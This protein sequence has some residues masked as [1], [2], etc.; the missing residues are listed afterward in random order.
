MAQ[1]N[2][3]AHHLHQIVITAITYI[4]N[5]F[6]LGGSKDINSTILYTIDGFNKKVLTMPKQHKKPPKLG[7]T[8]RGRKVK[9]LVKPWP[10]KTELPILAEMDKLT[11]HD[12]PFLEC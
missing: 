1:F 6:S 2:Y 7:E 10:Y 4:F 9:N 11:L 8:N 3:M 12:I 5:F